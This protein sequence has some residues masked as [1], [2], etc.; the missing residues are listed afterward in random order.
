MSDAVLPDASLDVFGREK[1]SDY[2]DDM[3][4]VGSFGRQNRTLYIGKLHSGNGM[5]NVLVKHFDEW[6]DIERI[7]TL[8]AKGVGFVTYYSELSAQF[9]KEAMMNQSADHDEVLNVR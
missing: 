6:G 5:E 4:G 2:R 9:A 8:Q 7:K 3:G 1:H